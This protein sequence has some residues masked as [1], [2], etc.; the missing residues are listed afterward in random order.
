VRGS[1]SIGETGPWSLSGYLY[2]RIE[3]VIYQHRRECGLVILEKFA[4]N[5]VSASNNKSSR[6]A[7]KLA[8]QE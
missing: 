8:S 6:F 3:L 5:H 7:V 2:N 4:S 1:V